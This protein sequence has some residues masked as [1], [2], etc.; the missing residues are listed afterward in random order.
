VHAR[1]QIDGDPADG[2]VH[3]APERPFPLVQIQLRRT[4]D[5]FTADRL[6]DL[7]HQPPDTGEE[8]PAPLQPCVRPLDLFL[9]RRDEHHVQAQRIGAVLLDHVVGIDHVPLGLRHDL[10]VLEDHA[11]GQQ[12][13]ERLVQVRHAQIAEDPAEE[14][15]INQVQDRVLDPAAVEINR[16]PIGDLVRIERQLGVLRIAEPEEVPRGIDERVH[17]VG[18][19]P[20]RT[21][22]FG[23][24]RVDELGDLRER[25][26]PLAAELGHLG[27]QDGQAVGG[28]RHHPVR[29]AVD[30]RDRRA[31]VALS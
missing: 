28:Q 24:R 30:D 26:V 11:L 12:P 21:A 2:V 10:A 19:A 14:P 29:L 5:P 9:W 25:R 31:P 27:Q 3:L 22:A 13:R 15:R 1:V 7:I 8:P 16:S 18:L 17:R 4:R 20:G 23:A 6:A